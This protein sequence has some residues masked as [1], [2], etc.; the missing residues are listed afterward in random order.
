MLIKTAGS[1]DGHGIIIGGTI[2]AMT[3]TTGFYCTISVPAF[4]FKLFSNEK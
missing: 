2:T 1:N 3:G 4:T